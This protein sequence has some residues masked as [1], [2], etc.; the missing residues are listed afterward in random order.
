MDWSGWCKK[1]RQWP[2]AT[3]FPPF[4]P[5][6]LKDR[7]SSDL[8]FSHHNMKTDCEGFMLHAM[9]LETVIQLMDCGPRRTNGHNHNTRSGNRDEQKPSSDEKKKGK[10]NDDCIN[11]DH[12]DDNRKIPICRWGPYKEK[13][14]WHILMDFRAYPDEE[15]VVFLSIVPKKRRRQGLENQQELKS[16]NKGRSLDGYTPINMSASPSRPITV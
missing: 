15:K 7:Q 11:N 2:L 13:Y 8:S 9:E 6:L 16:P 5:L 1:N 12:S 3:S 14:L 4:S 10:Q